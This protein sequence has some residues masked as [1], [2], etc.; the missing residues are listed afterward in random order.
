M[1]SDEDTSLSE[2]EAP[3]KVE[4]EEEDETTASI[5]EEMQRML[6]QL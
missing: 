5:N 2:S 6:N 1:V 4:E 3:K